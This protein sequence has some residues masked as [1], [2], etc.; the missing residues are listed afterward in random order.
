LIHL[1]VLAPLTRRRALN[2]VPNELHVDYYRQRAS[3]GGLLITEGTFI[4]RE[5]GGFPNAP[6]IYNQEQIQA[7]KRV[8]DAVHDKG[9]VIYCQLWAIGRANFGQMEDVRIVSSSNIPL[10]SGKVP[11]KMTIQDINRYLESYK[12]AT[13]N[14]IE[15]GFDGVEVHSAHGYLLDQ[16]IQKSCNDRDDEYGG[17]LENR[18]RFVLQVMKAV[19]AVIGQKRTAIRLSPYSFFQGMGKENYYETFGYISKQLQMRF[20]ELAYV[21]F[22]DPRLDEEQG[23]TKEV[24]QH[25][26]DYFRAIFRGVDPEITIG[27]S[28]NFEEPNDTYPT[29]FLSA[30]GYSASDCEPVADRTNDLIGFGRFFISNPDLPYRLKHGLELNAYDRSTFYTQGH[31]GYTTYSFADKDTKKF[32]PPS[33][34]LFL[35]NELLK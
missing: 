5:A 35:E 12:Q 9:G 32:V 18:A 20:P 23:G 33:R 8:T 16:F 21:S 30:G 22:T 25:T 13:L 10:E 29:V 1:V 2:Q 28:M 17:T 19:S 24:M 4:S 34:Q 31:V 14:A 11:E 27:K 26:S 7:W 3:K 15:A 6:G